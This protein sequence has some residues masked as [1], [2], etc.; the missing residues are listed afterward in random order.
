MGPYDQYRMQQYQQ[1]AVVP[2]E[3]YGGP[4]GPEHPVYNDP[5]AVITFYPGTGY[6]PVINQHPPAGT[7]TN[8]TAPE[9]TPV[10]PWPQPAPSWW[11]QPPLVPGTG[12]MA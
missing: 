5:T 1:S 8:R 7:D 9:H 12:R 4:G 10:P 3:V 6:E 2:S 11:P